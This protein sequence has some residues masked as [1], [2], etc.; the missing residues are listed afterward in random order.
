MI[1]KKVT[2]YNTLDS[3]GEWKK[4]FVLTTPMIFVLFTVLGV[5]FYTGKITTV[6]GYITC[7]MVSSKE[8]Q[9]L[10]SK[11]PNLDKDGDGIACE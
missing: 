3:N 4:Y 6:S 10:I 9:K 7:S 1:F 11:Y 2:S 8:A 5:M